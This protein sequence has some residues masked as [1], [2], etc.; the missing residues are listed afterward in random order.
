MPS[1]AVPIRMLPE[2]SHLSAWRCASR[3]CSMWSSSASLADRRFGVAVAAAQVHV[4]RF[5]LP[6]R[7]STLLV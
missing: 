2:I 4:G 1:A 5:M 6:R 7:R 3:D